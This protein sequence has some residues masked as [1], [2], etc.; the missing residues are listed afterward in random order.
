MKT[1]ELNNDIPKGFNSWGNGKK[2]KDIKDGLRG[3]NG[4]SATKKFFYS[5]PHNQRSDG[6]TP[7]ASHSYSS[8]NLG[9]AVKNPATA[10][11]IHT[12]VTVP[13]AEE[14]EPQAAALAAAVISQAAPAAPV[15]STATPAVYSETPS[16]SICC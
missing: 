7:A 12:V 2:N 3:Q 14:G 15:N 9:E 10:A 8:T 5:A 16:F 13:G 4:N 1:D 6:N 11:T